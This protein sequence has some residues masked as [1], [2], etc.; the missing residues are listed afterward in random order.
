[1]SDRRELRVLFDGQCGLC[2]H[3]VQFLYKREMKARFS[4]VPLQ[5]PYGKEL[6]KQIG[7]DPDDP[8]SFAVLDDNDTPFLRSSGAFLAL[9]HCTFPWPAIARVAGILPRVF[10]D[11]CYTYI[12]KRRLRFFGTAD[13]CSLEQAGLAERLVTLPR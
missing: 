1:M 4:F 10:T 5:S 9:R 11:G 7:I 2:S 6:A 13:V 12:A 3:S 8:S